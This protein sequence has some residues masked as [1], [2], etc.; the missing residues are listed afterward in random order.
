[1]E[2]VKDKSISE[3]S[4][5]S[6]MVEVQ[7][8][9]L[10][11]A[12]DQHCKL[13]IVPVRV[14]S[15][16]GQWTV[17]TYAFLDPGSTAS[18]CT[19]GL[20]DKLGLPGRKTKILLRTMGQEKVVDS[21]V[22][23][24]LEVAGLDSDVY[25][26]IPKLFVQQKMPVDRSNIPHQQDLDKWPHLK[27]VCLPEID[28]DVEILIGTNV[29][30]ALEPLEV[31][32]SMDGGPYAVKTVLGWTVNGPLGGCDD[33]PGCQ[34]TVSINRISAVTL[35]E[36]W[37]KQFK[38]DFPENNQDEL[39]GMS[40]DDCRFLKMADRSAKLVDGHYSIALPLKD[41]TLSM[42]NNRIIAEQRIVN[43]KRRFAR[44]PAF[45]KD[46]VEFMDNLIES[47]FAERVPDTDLER[48][49]G[50]VW[51]I[52]HHGVYHPQKKKM[53]VVFD[54]GA[55]FKEASL[56]A[57]LL[58]GPDLTSM[59]IGVL[60]RFRKEPI[61]LMSD[62]EAM[63]HQ[64]RVP[65]EDADLLRFLWWPNG[66]L[67]QPMVEYRMV[68]HLFGATSSPSCANFALRR[69]AED[70][71]D[72][73]SQHVFETIMHSFYVDDLLAS[74]AT[75]QE[76]IC[77]YKDL[78]KI[79]AKGGFNLT[80][81]ISN[82]RSVLAAIPEE[83]RA[84]E[85]KDLDLDQ[86]ILPVERALGVRWC[87]QSDTFGFSITIPEKPLTRRGILS[88]VG[89]FYDPLGILSP[90]IF[91]AK[92]ILQDLC[93]KGL[94]WDDAIPASAAQEWRDWVKELQTLDGFRTSRCLKPP[95]FGEITSAQL[96]HFA[97]AS[98]EGYGT[99]TYLLLHNHQG[100]AH[101]AFIMGKSRVAPLKTVTIPRMELT[102]AVVAAR[103]DKLWRR[104]LRMEL[105]DSVFWSDSTS[106][107]K[108]I[109]NETSRFRVFVANRVSEI[110][111]MSNPSQWRYVSTTCNPADLAS[112]G[113]RVE[114]F[115]KDEIWMCGPSFLLQPKEAWPVDPDDLG[116][117]TAGDPEVKVSA[118][119]SVEQEKD[120]AVTCLINRSSSWTRLLRV[121]AWI[122]KLKALLLNIRK[123]KEA[124]DQS[125][126]S[127]G[128]HKDIKMCCRYL[129]LEEIKNSEL[130][131]IK[132]CQMQK[133]SEEFS[134]LQRGESVKA[135]SH[136]YKLDPILDDGVL[137][138]GGRLSK[139]A[140][141]EESKHPAIIAK[142]LHISDLI[143]RHIHKAVGHGGRNHVLSK[144]R[145]RYW[146]PSASVAIRKI[147][148]RCVVCRRLHGTIGH[149]QMADLPA[150]R[151]SP[152][153]PPFSYVGVDYF[154][155]FDIKRGRSLVKRYGV[156]FTCL[157]I[158][159]VHI[160]VASSL[161]TS[162]FINALRRFMA[163]RGQVKEL[164][165]DNGTN[166]V[167]AERE[168]KLAIE[169][170]NLEQINDTLSQKGI[171][172]TFNPPT[173]SH[174]GGAWE[175]LIRSIRG[176]LNSTLRAQSL[177]EEG[178][179]TVL[180][181]VE[182][183]LNSRPLTKESTDLNDLEALTPNHLLLLKKQPCLP[184]G[185]FHKEDSYARRR[186]RQ[187]QYISDLFWKRWIKEYL[188][189]LQERQKWTKVKRN[190]VPGD[191]VLIVDDSAP[192]NSWVIGRITGTLPDR[193]GLVRQVQIKTQT[194]TLC[195]PVTKICL[196]Q[197]S[198]QV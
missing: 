160:E 23:S 142:D 147:L 21:G 137:R 29:P 110:L 107:L 197:E 196:L 132:F 170:W 16:K 179:Q 87:A 78:R 181:E 158:R 9:G 138:V 141:P 125:A 122:L 120:N 68:V 94:G 95:N 28:A 166:F 194:S 14:K 47:G 191:I 5:S 83:E 135:N 188:P 116:K 139:A 80:K 44:E 167:G 35:D 176:V 2:T 13:A 61:V 17:E 20:M 70:N 59:L 64:V 84:K 101:R 153:A 187:V 140:M 32:R 112:R 150:D 24:H 192:R 115:L 128:Q 123:R 1:M 67:S 39:V 106:V 189:Q 111:R 66:D 37:S 126:S 40:K 178:L 117:L 71:K 48:S 52:P 127:E 25:C 41:R 31:I 8:S 60:T 79:C 173:G 102:A 6:G 175:R 144:L 55:S 56:N 168:L 62:I 195:R 18:F 85:V 103:M 104:E 86:D 133:Y 89:S 161:D 15:T 121:M 154:G 46:Y 131:I 12:G 81:W 182:S 11:G 165:S 113:V 19:V 180:C 108:Y 177:D 77:L 114:S 129:S 119:V 10:T 157:V 100:L 98:E 118:I 198:A 45:H 96:H 42:P 171:K 72:F 172:W 76:A 36:L 169:G 159:A 75:E 156:I 143:I 54:C 93:R 7:T 27:H 4:S 43:L 30:N 185:L 97:D 49:D 91:T 74:V 149:Q 186:W 51:Y 63:F 73:F 109:K 90:V 58:Q 57:H 3:N 145:Q 33:S 34:S 164:R 38:M 146:I 174:H 151:V 26:E 152:D 163:R 130:E 148:S 50:K 124:T 190:F 162:S 183:I 105:Q 184:P 193:R 134:C 53:R 155:P 65:E 99:V 22:T 88:T 92:R 82:S 136:I 69:C